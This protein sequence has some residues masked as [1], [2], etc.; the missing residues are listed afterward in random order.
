MWVNSPGSP[1]GCAEEA[2]VA[3]GS[4]KGLIGA[5]A[6]WDAGGGGT[7]GA[8]CICGAAGAVIN[9]FSGS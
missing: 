5:G 1:N 3:E 9:G 7:G 6:P 2:A 4:A 8:L